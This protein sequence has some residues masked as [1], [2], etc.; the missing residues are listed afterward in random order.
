MLSAGE[1]RYLDVDLGGDRTNL[2]I[3]VVGW[4]ELFSQRVTGVST[5]PSTWYYSNTDAG[6]IAWGLINESQNETNGDFGITQGNIQTSVNRDRKEYDYDNIRDAIIALSEVENGFD[7]EI[8]PEKVFNVYYPKIGQS[9][10]DVVFT[11]PGNIRSL[12]FGR[13]GGLMGNQIIAVGSG[14]GDD[15]TQQIVDDTVLQSAYNLRQRVI[16]RNNVQTEATLLEH[17]NEELRV[18]KSF[19]DIPVVELDGN[20]DPQFGSYDI[21]DEVEIDISEQLEIFSPVNGKFRIEEI[22]LTVD[23]N[24]QEIVKLALSR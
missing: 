16:T 15:R 9:K 3:D 21:G 12:S 11:F 6:S 1:I 14:F 4:L 19:L 8:T 23:S 22:R 10:P 5:S 7:F 24:G 18:R 13:D 20:I 17:A 2:S